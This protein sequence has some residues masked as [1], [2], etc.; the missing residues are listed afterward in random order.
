MDYL[1]RKGF[2]G[3]DAA[4]VAQGGLFQQLQNQVSLLAFMDCFRILAWVTL[5]T[6]PLLLAIRHIKPRRETSDGALNPA[7]F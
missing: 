7:L 4:L 3:P 1:V 6:I 5:A 2:T